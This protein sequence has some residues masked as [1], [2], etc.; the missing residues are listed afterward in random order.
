M[1]GEGI[2]I[3]TRTCDNPAPVNGGR[4]CT[5]GDQEDRVRVIR[6]LSDWRVEFVYPALKRWVSRFYSII[7]LRKPSSIVITQAQGTNSHDQALD[8]PATSQATGPTGNVYVISIK[9]KGLRRRSP[10]RARHGI[11]DLATTLV[12]QY[13]LI[14]ISVDGGWGRWGNFGPCSVT[15]GQGYQ[16]RTRTCD[17]PSPQHGGRD[18]DSDS[19]GVT[20]CK[21]EC[22]SVIIAAVVVCAGLLVLVAVIFLIKRKRLT[23]AKSKDDSKQQPVTVRYSKYAIQVAPGKEPVNDHYSECATGG[24]SEDT[25]HYSE[26][27]AGPSTDTDNYGCGLLGKTGSR[28]VKM[29]E[30][31][32]YSHTKPGQPLDDGYDVFVKK[33]DTVDES[34]I[35]DHAGNCMNEGGYESFQG[36]KIAPVKNE[37]SQFA[38][39]K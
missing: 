38:L 37:Y 4:E 35:Y 30:E 18:C 17:N 31:D 16:I 24:P 19:S 7:K 20:P 5:G 26:G 6:Y 29:G 28:S 25:N 27:T 10:A 15:C 36:K 13:V 3:R 32:M 2:Q 12:Y 11:Q 22:P 9:V 14:S 34:G 21:N 33:K 8:T 1:C 39:H 23:Q